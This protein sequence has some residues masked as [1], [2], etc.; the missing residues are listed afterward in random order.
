MHVDAPD[1]EYFPVGHCV[2]AAA[3]PGR[4]VAQNVLAAQFWQDVVDPDV[5]RYLPLPQLVQLPLGLD[6]SYKVL[7]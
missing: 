3:V 2:H 4:S 5:T 7:G 6:V 1:A